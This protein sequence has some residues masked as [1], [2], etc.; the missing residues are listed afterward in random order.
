MKIFHF[1][2]VCL[3][4]T[5]AQT[6]FAA[7]P[8]SIQLSYDVLKSG[9]KV[10]R[11]EEIYTRNNDHYTLSSIT[12]PTG[13]LAVFRPEKIFINSEG[14][15]A[16]KGLRPL[17]FK[18]QRERDDSKESRAEFDW[19]AKQLALIHLDQRNLT[20][21]PDGTQD[22]LSAMYQ[23]MFLPLQS[24]NELEFSMTNGNK[25][26]HYHYAITRYQK[27]ETPAGEFTTIYLDSQA[28]AGESRTEIWLATKLHN[29][30][31]KMV[32]TDSSGGQLTQELSKVQIEP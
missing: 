8:N 19:E 22:R 2:W 18:H 11:I 6:L 15:V 26:D 1:V 9:A 29:L 20:D 31:C 16:K 5:F 7:P 27:T 13:I 4:L 23:F 30:P 25:L 32:V 28:Q 24:A 14:L 3:A 12:T 10:G 17:Q 21:L